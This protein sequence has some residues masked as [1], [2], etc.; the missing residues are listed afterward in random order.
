[1]ND[2]RE[3]LIDVKGLEAWYGKRRI[4]S[5]VDFRVDAGEIR[6]IMGGSGSGKS[7]LLR[8]LLGLHRPTAGRIRLLGVDVTAAGAR[9]MQAVRRKIGVSFQG[10]ALLTSLSVGDNVA[11]PL[12]EHYREL[13]ENQIR[14]MSRMKLEI[15]NL[16]GFHDLM[17]SQLSGGMVGVDPLGQIPDSASPRTKPSLERRAGERGQVAERREPE[18]FQPL[19]EIE[20]D[21][22]PG[23]R[24][25]AQKGSELICFDDAHAARFRLASGDRGSE[26]AGSDPHSRPQDRRGQG[27]ELGRCCCR[28]G[29]VT[30]QSCQ[31]DIV[32]F[33]AFRLDCRAERLERGQNPF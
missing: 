22:Q 15:V 28:G 17:P 32:A 8:H 13:D 6:V 27:K 21:R 18:P 24:N 4:L 7:T 33:G 25:S 9:E 12:R 5:E 26:L 23:D 30:L 2:A 19:D 16:G 31:I 29:V 11:L 3:P 1:M 14:I 10:G 20:F